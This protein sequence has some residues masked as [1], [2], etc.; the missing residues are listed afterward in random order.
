M[1]RPV[2]YVT[3]CDICDLPVIVP[4]LIGIL[5]YSLNFSF[6]RCLKALAGPDLLIIE[7]S[8]SYSGAPHSLRLPWTRD[9]PVAET[10]T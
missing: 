5:K 6:L 2:Y 9:R 4:Y 1:K 10:S 3:Y 7:V 8:R